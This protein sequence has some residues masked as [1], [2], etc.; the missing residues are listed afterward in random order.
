MKGLISGLLAAASLLA[1]GTV[2]IFGTVTDASG[3]QIPG[4]TVTIAH[5]ETGQS[6]SAVSNERGD[7]VASQ[8]PIGAYTV[9]ASKTGFKKFVQ[10]GIRVQVDDNRQ[11]PVVLQV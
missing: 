8:L 11:V 5:L 3:S 1:Q 10:T 7:Y 2:T 4:V 6:R 9:S